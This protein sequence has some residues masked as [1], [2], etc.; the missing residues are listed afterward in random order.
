VKIFENV[1]KN[2]SIIY[3]LSLV[4]IIFQIQPNEEL[5][6]VVII[7][8]IRQSLLDSLHQEAESSSSSFEI[9]LQ[10]QAKIRSSIQKY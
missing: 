4:Y 1:I 5:F 8:I 10:K 9:N 2:K 7:V 3:S 6:D